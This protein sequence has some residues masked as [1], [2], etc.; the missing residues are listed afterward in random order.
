MRNVTFLFKVVA[1]A[2]TLAGIASGC[3]EKA[4]YVDPGGPDTVVT[5]NQI[6]IQDWNRA[7]TEMVQSLLNS[8]VL[9]SAPR[10]P[11][12]MAISRI[13]N[14]TSENVDVDLLTKNIRVALNQ[15]GKVR[16]STTIGLGGTAEDPLAKGSKQME[17]F[18]S[19]QHKQMP[20]LP[21]YTLSGKILELPAK[22][23]RIRQITYVF[24]LSLTDRSGNAVWEE[25]RQIT[26]QGA[27]PAV[28]W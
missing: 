11:A 9:D 20:D 8:G 4:K 5:L 14:K 17:E 19:G 22:A 25:Q 24:Q 27:K 6:D 12:I 28:G 15:S 23:G 10:K 21:D 7:S 2:A 18:Y 13:T 26:K 16:T 3:Q 1:G